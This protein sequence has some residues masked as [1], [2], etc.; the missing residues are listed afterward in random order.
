MVSLLTKDKM[1]PKEVE[2]FILTVLAEYIVI[3]KIVFIVI[4]FMV[5]Q[6]GTE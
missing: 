5:A 1:K 2:M 3:S 4:K 6:S